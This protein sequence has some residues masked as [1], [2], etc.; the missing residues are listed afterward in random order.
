M[1][2]STVIPSELASVLEATSTLTDVESSRQPMFA[3]LPTDCT[4]WGVVDAEVEEDEDCTAA[5]G[6]IV[7]RDVVTGGDDSADEDLDDV[8]GGAVCRVDVAG[9]G[10]DARV[11]EEVGL[12]PP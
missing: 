4:A 11:V 10:E 1:H 12:D 5:T 2:N 6:G 9:G 8:T 7:C 3:K